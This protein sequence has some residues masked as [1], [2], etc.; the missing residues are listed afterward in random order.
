MKLSD[1]EKYLSSHGCSKKREGG[2]HTI[3]ENPV[4]GKISPVPRHKEIKDRL[5]NGIC[6][7]LEIALP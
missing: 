1:L 4:N 3:W 2:R 5:V 7:Q 6:K